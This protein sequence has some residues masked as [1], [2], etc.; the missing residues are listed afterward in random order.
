MNPSPNRGR[1]GGNA[2]PVA[3]GHPDDPRLE[4]FAEFLAAVDRS[5]WRAGQV[6]TRRLAA[7]V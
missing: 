3:T 7:W 1:N 6:A 2:P 4:S 5:D